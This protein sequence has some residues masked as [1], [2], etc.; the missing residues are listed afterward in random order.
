[1]DVCCFFSLLLAC[2][3]PLN[4]DSPSLQVAWEERKS[5]RLARLKRMRA[6]LAATMG[7]AHKAAAVAM[8]V[9]V[10]HGGAVCL[11]HSIRA[12]RS[13]QR[14]GLTPQATPRLSR[15]AVSAAYVAT[16]PVPTVVDKCKRPPRVAPSLP[17]SLHV[18]PQGGEL[19]YQSSRVGVAARVV[20]PALG[21]AA[22]CSTRVRVSTPPRLRTTRT[23]GPG[24]LVA[25][26]ARTAARAAAN[27]YHEL[28]SYP[29]SFSRIAIVSP[30][31]QSVIRRRRERAAEEAFERDIMQQ[32]SFFQA[33]RQNGVGE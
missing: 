22:A 23:K 32:C 15:H 27:T 17:S 11:A 9:D 20:R 16:I 26:R 5:Q 1:M 19:R 25:A 8:R 6:E 12:A 29:T 13:R 28:Q 31:Y 18:V 7:S 21:D 14:S 3:L 24:A 10:H 30:A 33:A 4:G 2:R